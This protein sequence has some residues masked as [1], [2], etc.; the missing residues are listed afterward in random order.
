MAVAKLGRCH[1]LLL[2]AEYIFL[3]PEHSVLLVTKQLVGGSAV[4]LLFGVFYLI[5]CRLKSGLVALHAR[6]RHHSAALV[7]TGPDCTSSM[8]RRA[9]DR[10][11]PNRLRSTLPQEAWWRWLG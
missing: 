7:P 10:H 6:T 9:A 3:K 5:V 2:Q 1:T 11:Q 4:V 8:A